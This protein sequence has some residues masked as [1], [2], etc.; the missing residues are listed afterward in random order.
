MTTVRE[1]LVDL[2]AAVRSEA[3]RTDEWMGS[4]LQRAY[5]AA[6]VVLDAP[7]PSDEPEHGTFVVDLGR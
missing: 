6:R 1:A 5:D 7:E 4:E 2:A 3:N